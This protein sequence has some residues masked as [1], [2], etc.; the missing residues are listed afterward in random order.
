MGD[1][2][3]ETLANVT[4]GEFDFDD[5]AFLEIS[6]NAQDFIQCALQ[7]NPRYTSVKIF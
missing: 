1:S 3:S 2:E 6:E 5:D 4:R 7:K